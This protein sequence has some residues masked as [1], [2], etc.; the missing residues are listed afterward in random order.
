M[1]D[2]HSNGKRGAVR[3]LKRLCSQTGLALPLTAV[4]PVWSLVRGDWNIL[5]FPDMFPLSASPF[6]TTAFREKGVFPE[7][8]KERSSELPG[9]GM[10]QVIVIVLG[11]WREGE[12]RE[13][14]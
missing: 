1:Q 3:P 8:Q 9:T 2:R 6:S 12:G 13:L 11:A 4:V 14:A 10:G 5:E 7:V